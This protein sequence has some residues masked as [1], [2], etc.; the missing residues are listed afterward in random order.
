MNVGYLFEHGVVPT[1]ESLAQ[2]AGIVSQQA[3]TLGF[4]DT[5]IAVAALAGVVVPLVL[6]FP[7]SKAVSGVA[8]H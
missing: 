1:K 4:S 3:S 5:M 7:R 2:V 8:A 6:A